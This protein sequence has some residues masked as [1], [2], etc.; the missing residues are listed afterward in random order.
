MARDIKTAHSP[1][2]AGDARLFVEMAVHALCRL[3]SMGRAPVLLTSLDPPA[4][5]AFRGDLGLSDLVE[6]RVRDLAGPYPWLF[7]AEQLLPDVSTDDLRLLPIQEL[8]RALDWGRRRAALAA[9]EFLTWAGERLLP[10]GPKWG[11]SLPALRSDQLALEL[12]GSGG[13]Y[14]FR[15]T[16]TSVELL[17]QE[18]FVIACG[19]WR[20]AVF[21]GLVGLELQVPSGVLLPACVDH[22]L[23]ATFVRDRRYD[24]ILGGKESHQDHLPALGRLLAPGG[25][26]VLL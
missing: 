25:Q 18:N 17:V 20:E 24:L 14:A 13:L 21:A 19:S 9:E 5:R 7:D 4:W 10:P 15:L 3:E 8:Q 23:E 11:P 6:M 16:Q 1:T 26:V 12:P 22:E 2:R